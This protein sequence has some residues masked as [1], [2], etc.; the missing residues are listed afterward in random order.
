MTFLTRP[1]A[2]LHQAQLQARVSGPGAL[3]AHVAALDAEAA[4]GGE[5]A[6][7]RSDIAEGA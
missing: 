5:P 7:E 2:P 6:H 1:D 3:A 4:A